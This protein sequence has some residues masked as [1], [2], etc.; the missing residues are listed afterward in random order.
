[1]RGA[2]RKGGPY[3][4]SEKAA[5]DAA[6]KEVE[7]RVLLAIY[8]EKLV[9]ANTTGEAKSTLLFELKRYAQEVVAASKIRRR[10]D[11]NAENI[12]RS[13]VLDSVSFVQNKQDDL[14]L[15][16]RNLISRG[17]ILRSVFATDS[18]YAQH[19]SPNGRSRSMS[20]EAAHDEDDRC[21]R[22]VACAELNGVDAVWRGRCT[23]Y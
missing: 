3:R 8:V 15:S 12:M 4:D 18:L 23:Y 10:A 9:P 6:L 14:C 21:R 22:W 17:N 2:A 13:H 20:S 7:G 1:M 16:A 11:R 19:A 5:A